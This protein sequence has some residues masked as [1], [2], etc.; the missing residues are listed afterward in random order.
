MFRGV[1]AN[2]GGGDTVLANLPCVEPVSKQHRHPN[3]DHVRPDRA[4]IRKKGF[5][6][7][8]ARIFPT[9]KPPVYTDCKASAACIDRGWGSE[10][11]L[12]YDFAGSLT[13][14]NH[15]AGAHHE[16]GGN[17]DTSEPYIPALSLLRRAET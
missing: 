6:Y 11:F 5:C 10:G 2:L 4:E 8:L 1:S 12:Q 16:N 9:A 3:T 13:A 14:G 17:I 7:E 15:Q